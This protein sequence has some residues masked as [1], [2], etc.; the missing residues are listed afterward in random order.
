VQQCGC[1]CD[2][3]EKGFHKFPL[4]R[5]YNSAAMM[6]WLHVLWGWMP[7]VLPAISNFILV[8]LGIVLSFPRLTDSIEKNTTHQ[9]LLAIICL[10]F[11]GVGL[12][13]DISQR[14]SSEQS[15]KTLIGQTTQ[16]V[17]N[18]NNLVTTTNDLAHKTTTMVENTNDVVSRIGRLEPLIATTKRMVDEEVKR[19]AVLPL[20]DMTPSE[21]SEQASSLANLMRSLT[22]AYSNQDR[23]ID[24]FYFDR[25]Q[26]MGVRWTQQQRNDWLAEEKRKRAQ[27]QADYEPRALKLIANANRLREV[28]LDKIIP[29]E[30]PRDEHIEEVFRNPHS[31]KRGVIFTLYDIAGYLEGLAKLLLQ[32]MPR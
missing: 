25:L 9:R 5:G 29:S 10:V 27:L 16:T 19:L 2:G 28:M 23:N 17:T 26:G 31:D 12:I 30:S 1:F 3:A 18:T 11:G 4:R 32:P 8:I 7:Y 6:P 21:L 13:F 20:A 14:A 22:F 24:N 15:I